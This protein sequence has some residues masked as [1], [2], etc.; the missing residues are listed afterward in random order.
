MK[1]NRKFRKQAFKKLP[2]VDMPIIYHRVSDG[3]FKT[4]DPYT[5]EEQL[6]D[7]KY[8]LASMKK[9]LVISLAPGHVLELVKYN[10]G[11]MVYNRNDKSKTIYCAPEALSL[12]E[13]ILGGIVLHKE[14]GYELHPLMSLAIAY[15]KYHYPAEYDIVFTGVIVEFD[16]KDN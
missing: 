12:Y 16:P 9:P 8:V 4:A 11:E 15:F 1:S 14:Y 6:I 2:N 13:W 3:W 5:G 7:E 10:E